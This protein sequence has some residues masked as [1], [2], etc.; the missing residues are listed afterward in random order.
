MLPIIVRYT[1]RYV[2]TIEQCNVTYNCET[3]HTYLTYIYIY[4]ERYIYI[5]EEYY[6][7]IYVYMTRTYKVTFYHGKGIW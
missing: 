5:N 6:I 4:V 7:Y 2:L 3:S 1:L